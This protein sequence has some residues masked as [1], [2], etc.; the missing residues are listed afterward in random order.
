MNGNTFS[1]LMSN[2]VKEKKKPPFLCQHLSKSR[3]GGFSFFLLFCFWELDSTLQMV[4]TVFQENYLWLNQEKNEFFFSFFHADASTN[5]IIQNLFVA[6]KNKKKNSTATC[7]PWS[8][9]RNFYS[10][11]QRTKKKLLLREKYFRPLP[12]MHVEE[13]E[14]EEEEEVLRRSIQ[15]K[16]AVN[17]RKGEKHEI[18]GKVTGAG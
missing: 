8:S 7:R 10:G 16:E 11:K 17:H 1:S 14:E 6:T 18:F 12:V 15:E 9:R 13:E 4:G 3:N 5:K 2:R